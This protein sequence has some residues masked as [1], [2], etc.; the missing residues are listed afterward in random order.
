M[1]A[2]QPTVLPWH[3]EAAKETYNH[4]GD[5]A[6]TSGVEP[7]AAIIARHDEGRTDS[8]A[9]RLEKNKHAATLRLLAQA[10]TAMRKHGLSGEADALQDAVRSIVEGAHR[11]AHAD[12]KKANETA[13]D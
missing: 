2:E 12:G 6:Y 5:W 7:I 9:L 4:I 1:S 8:P 13:T 3:R 10:E 11:S